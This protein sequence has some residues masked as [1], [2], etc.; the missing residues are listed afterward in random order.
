LKSKT[1][2]RGSTAEDT[3][4]RCFFMAWLL[5]SPLPTKIRINTRATLVSRIAAR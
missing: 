5:A 4:H 1:F 2:F 3:A